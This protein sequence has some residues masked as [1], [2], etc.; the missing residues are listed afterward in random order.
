[1]VEIQEVEEQSPTEQV[2]PEDSNQVDNSLDPE[3]NVRRLSVSNLARQ[4]T[5]DELS[6]TGVQKL[7]IEMLEDAENENNELKNYVSKYHI[8]DK[9][10]GILAEKLLKDNIIDVFFGLGIG[11]GGVILG[12]TP[13]FVKLGALYGIVCGMIGLLLIIGSS[14]GRLLKK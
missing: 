2:I 3:T 11:I 12:L 8:A 6:T 13:Y 1:M 4:L 9:Q 5:E 14:I 10:V 7:I